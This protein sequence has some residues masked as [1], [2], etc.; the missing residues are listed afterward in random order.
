MF[1]RFPNHRLS[2]APMIDWTDRFCRLFHRQFT[3]KTLLYT[4]MM[5]TG[6][7]LRG[8]R[9]LIGF[10][11]E[12]R[13][14]ALQL[15][16]SDPADLAAATAIGRDLGYD[17]I[18][19]NVGCPSDR[20][21]SGCFGAVLMR[22]PDL[23]TDC[24]AAMIE[25]AGPVPVTVKCRIGVDEQDPE[26]VLPDFLLRMRAAGVR[27]VAVHARKAWLE[28]LSPRQNREIP[29]LD[30]GLV[31]RMARAFP[32]LEVVG[33]GGIG[34]LAEAAAMIGQGLA[35]A[36]IG[37][38][39]YQ[40]PALLGAADRRIFGAAG[41]DVGPEAAVERMLPFIEDELAAGAR[42]NQITRHM[43]GAFH[44]RPG[45]RAWRRLLSEEAHRTGAGVALVER[46]LAEVA[47]EPISF[48]CGARTALGAVRPGS[49]VDP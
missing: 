33:N 49:E 31:L 6:A 36:M 12:E 43:L 30:H 15:G 21:Q 7:V 2:V 44:G 29:P 34:G 35:G 3:R 38:A 32:D 39:A 16:G 14:V 40:T 1:N 17:E 41:P 20:V 47:S 5:T 4:E 48:A 27:R 23:V 9:D 37:R 26:V 25:A 13:P 19:L 24:V 8:R 45:A 42:L 10:R 18:N 28:G 22:T 11:P 46:A